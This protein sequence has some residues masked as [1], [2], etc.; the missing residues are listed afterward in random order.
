MMNI[1]PVPPAEEAAGMRLLF[2][3]STGNAGRL[4]TVSLCAGIGFLVL[5][6][7]KQDLSSNTAGISNCSCNCRTTALLSGLAQH[8]KAYRR[9][10]DRA[11]VETTVRERNVIFCA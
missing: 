1:L 9:F 5:Y 8:R 7:I 3:L 2:Q 4:S 6:G 10:T 11:Q